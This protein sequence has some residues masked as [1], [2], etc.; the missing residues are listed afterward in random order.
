MQAVRL[1]ST[2]RG[3]D[4]RNYT[5][6][7]FGGAGALMAATIADELG[8]KRV[9]VPRYAGLLSSFGLLVAD[10]IRD[11]VQTKVSLCVETSA[12]DLASQFGKMREKPKRICAITGSARRA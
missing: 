1:A 12:E 7:A 9:L 3:Y 2:E 8:M 4:A 6:V 5:M 11:Y 10:I